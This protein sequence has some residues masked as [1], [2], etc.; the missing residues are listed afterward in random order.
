MPR[1]LKAAELGRRPHLQVAIA[2][3][4]NQPARRA[5]NSISREDSDSFNIKFK[6]KCQRRDGLP[7]F[8]RRQMCDAGAD[9]GF[10]YGLEIV[11]IRGT[12]IRQTVGLGQH[13][14]GG[15]AADR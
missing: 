6:R 1:W 2:Q 12:R 11:K 7:H 13:D 9:L 4:R 10:G 5:A 14:L 15:Y 3:A 8:A